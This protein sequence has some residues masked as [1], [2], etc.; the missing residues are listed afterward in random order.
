[1]YVYAFADV[2]DTM[3]TQ[4]VGVRQ[5]LLRSFQGEASSGRSVQLRAAGQ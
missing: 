3:V 2:D 5:Q 4:R 1:V